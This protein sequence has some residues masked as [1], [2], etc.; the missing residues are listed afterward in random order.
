MWG[1]GDVGHNRHRCAQT[2]AGG[3]ELC[4]AGQGVAGSLT[5]LLSLDITLD[6]WG[7]TGLAGPM[8]GPRRLRQSNSLIR[9]WH[10]Q[11]STTHHLCTLQRRLISAAVRR[12]RAVDGDV[13]GR[14]SHHEAS[15]DG[16][17]HAPPRSTSADTPS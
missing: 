2:H 4:V 11:A 16:A 13:E 15:A 14:P 10:L 12:V 8:Q 5:L 7:S 3:E 1:C 9:D 17:W 6:V